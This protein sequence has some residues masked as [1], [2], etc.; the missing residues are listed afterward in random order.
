MTFNPVL[1]KGCLLACADMV[2]FDESNRFVAVLQQLALAHS[3]TLACKVAQQ[4]SAIELHWGLAN[5]W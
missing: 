5:S 4:L 1:T 2:R 3:K